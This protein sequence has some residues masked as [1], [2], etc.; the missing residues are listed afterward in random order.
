MSTSKI[1][2]VRLEKSELQIRIIAYIIMGFTSL[3]ALLP[4]LN[5]IAKSFS[6]GTAVTA[7]KVVFWPIG[8]QL[9]SYW[10]VLAESDFLLAMRNSL[11][12]TVMGVTINMIVSVMFAYPLSRSDLYGKKLITIICMVAMVF[13][14]GTVPTYLIVRSLGLFNKFSS[15]IIPSCM[16]IFDMLI[17]RNYFESLPESVM[18]SASL[19]GATDFQILFHLVIP[20]S[21]PV[22]ATVGLLYAIGYWN[23]YFHAML[24]ITKPSMITLQVFIRNFISD[25]GT[26][27]SQLE[28]NQDLEGVVTSGNIIACVT[29]LGVVPIVVIYPFIQKY[30]AKGMTIGSEKG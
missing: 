17:I 8:F 19:D 2:K 4:C 26:L 22:I 13:S 21:T 25:C 23:S 30:L 14:G 9:T 20:M 6:V 12:V 24:Y 27:V 16:S 29:V 11:L 5:V 15:L 28:R 18:E 7:G 10:A 1:R 3:V